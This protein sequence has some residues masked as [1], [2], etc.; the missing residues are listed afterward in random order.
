MMAKLKLGCLP[1]RVETA[2]YSIPRL[3]ESE[4]YC[5]VC[6]NHETML[7]T[8]DLGSIENEA[9]FLFQCRSFL[10]ERE[11]WFSNMSLPANFESLSFHEKFKTVLNI[12]ENIKPTAIFIFNAYNQR[13]K[14]LK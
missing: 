10:N 13:S 7:D 4:R 12:P 11:I 9:H 5:L 2:R 14:I 8:S 6:K 1:I 3:P